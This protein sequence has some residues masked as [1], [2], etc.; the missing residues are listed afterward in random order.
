MSNQERQQTICNPNDTT[1]IAYLARSV[2]RGRQQSLADFW[3]F[4]RLVE[5]RIAETRSVLQLQQGWTLL[6]L[7][8]G[9]FG[10]STAP[11]HGMLHAR[12]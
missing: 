10:L 6:K 7:I 4:L 5:L 12:L 11:V 1:L 2:P 9:R 8:V 3:L